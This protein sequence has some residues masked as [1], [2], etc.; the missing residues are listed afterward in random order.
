MLIAFQSQQ[1]S[2]IHTFTHSL[3]QSISDASEVQYVAHFFDLV[4][5]NL[6]L[7]WRLITQ[8]F[9]N[10]FAFLPGRRLLIV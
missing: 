9:G 3:K 4:D 2:S 10:M 7:H 5:Q 1:Q 8:I 6:C